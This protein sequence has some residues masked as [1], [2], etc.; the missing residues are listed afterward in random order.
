MSQVFDLSNKIPG[1]DLYMKT[2]F[3]RYIAFGGEFP[4]EHIID[5][6][7][8]IK[9]PRMFGKRVFPGFGLTL[10]TPEQASRRDALKQA[11]GFV[12]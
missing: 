7:K 8:T 1:T 9:Y 12:E 3:A 2:Y 4:D 10:Y 11:V 6:M 5:Y